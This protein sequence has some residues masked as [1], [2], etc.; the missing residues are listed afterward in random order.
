MKQTVGGWDDKEPIAFDDRT[1]YEK[2]ITAAISKWCSKD[3]DTAKKC[4]GE[5]IR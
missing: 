4:C 1:E 2:N 5:D 3:S